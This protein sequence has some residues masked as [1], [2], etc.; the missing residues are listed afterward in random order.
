MQAGSWRPLP[1]S[2]AR[3]FR[4]IIHRWMIRLWSPGTSLKFA[5]AWSTGS[6]PMTSLRRI[7]Y[8]WVVVAVAAAMGFITSAVRFAAAALVPFLRDSSAGFGWSY[9]AI[10]LAFSLQWI[11]LG[12]ASPYVG[13]LG[14]RYGVRRLLLLGGLLFFAGMLLTGVMK[15]LW[16]FYLYFGV[17]LGI[18]SA[19]Y[20]VVTV[21]G[22]HL[23]V[24]EESGPGLGC[25]VVFP[26][27]GYRGSPVSYRRGLRHAG[28]EVDFLATG[29]NRRSRSWSYWPGSFTTIRAP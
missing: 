15:S 8:A 21:S 11:V 2:R 25:S 14:E 17:L 6:R 3:L 20:T 1:S 19:I 27:I 5:R 13:L 22:G 24:Q 7:H 26:G 16:E 18:A 10:S 29:H 23:V 9:G 4:S 28:H 12:I